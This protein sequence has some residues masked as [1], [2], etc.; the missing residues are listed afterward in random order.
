[1]TPSKRDVTLLFATRITRLF[2]Y[3]FLSV[4]LALYLAQTGLSE[5]QIGVLFTLTLIGDAALSLWMTTSADRL[6]RQRMLL[7]GA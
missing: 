3:G 7:L 1:M 4:V 6:G 5:G 2:A